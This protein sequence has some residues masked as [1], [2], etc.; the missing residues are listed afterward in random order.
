MSTQGKTSTF[1]PTGLLLAGLC[2]I[3]TGQRILLEGTGHDVANYGGLLLCAIAIG[4]RLRGFVNASGD[5]RAVEGRLLAAYAGVGV[6]LGLYALSTPDGIAKLGLTGEG[7]DR[8]GGALLGAW[9]AVMLVS[10]VAALFAEL[11]YARMPIAASVELRRVS[12]AQQAGVS[13]ALAAV[14][15]LAM[16]Y[17]ATARDV[18]K[19]VSYFKTTEPSD[20]TRAMIAKLDQKMKVVLFFERGSDVLS[21]ARPY[22]EALKGASNKLSYEVTDVAL[23]PT[24]G[25]KHKVRDN[26]HVLLLRGEGDEQ[27]GEVFRLGT[28]LTEARSNLRKLDGMFQQAF[29]KLVR[30]ERTL[31]LTVG[32][33]ER[34]AKGSELR[35]ED[36]VTVMT[37][38]L[39]RLNLKTT[40]IGMAQGLG[41]EIPAAAS[42]VLIMG[43][44]EPFLPEEVDT[45][46]KY[47]RDG[48]KLLVMVDPDKKTGLERLL[49]GVGV[50]V[51]PG[52]V[53]SSTN[54]MR[55]AHNASDHAIIYSNQ[56]GAHPSVT[57]ATRHQREVATVLV[58]A[59]ALAAS[60]S[61]AEPKPRVTFPIRSAKEF[62]RDLDGDFIRGAGETAEQLNLAAAATI[63]AEGDKEGRAV[64]IGDS[65]FM[66]DKIA[67]N[68]GNYLVFVDMLAWLVG[69]E[70]LSGEVSS[71]EDVAIE[72]TSER[73]KVWFYVTTF[74]VPAPIVALG[75][76]V[77]RRRRRRSEVKS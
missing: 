38:I 70:E 46:L 49:D 47:V 48:G 44:T 73:D 12:T 19:D 67:P 77:A 55:R 2:A 69:N 3:F 64:V 65:D 8:A 9:L 58:N 75:L 41:K 61:K 45:L 16:N 56:Y 37:D 25:T 63:K 51:L 7:A 27:K 59:A 17:V 6:A 33:G 60:T 10:L 1:L 71:E 30:P 35:D 72:H 34:N 24:L 43:P 57:T 29:S 20:G 5:V 66:S 26:G 21:Q 74:A 39:K 4:L 54:F 28:E 36:K 76:W 42:A 11:A 50:T 13:L 23:A 22:F 52:T 18:R 40:D 32:H 31:Y 62:W 14:F 15:L 53:A 68:Q